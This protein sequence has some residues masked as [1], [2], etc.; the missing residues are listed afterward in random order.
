MRKKL[1]LMLSLFLICAIL[2]GTVR[3]DGMVISV[4]PQITGTI[5]PGDTFLVNI[6]IADVL[7]PGIVQWMIR[8]KW[9][10]TILNITTVEDTPVIIEGNFLKSKG[11][12]M[13]L[14]TPVNYTDGRIEE[15]FCVLLVAGAKTGSGNLCQINFTAVHAD[16]NEIGIYDSALVNETGDVLPHSVVNATVTVIPEFPAS[17]LL[18]IFLAT[19]TIFVLIVKTVLLR[20]RRLYTSVP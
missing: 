6:D 17:M 15:M 14:Y 3:G 20:K 18:P 5:E 2:T 7:A 9:D 4:N 1:T 11:S 13:F 12:T 8:L 10:P 16:G 19:T